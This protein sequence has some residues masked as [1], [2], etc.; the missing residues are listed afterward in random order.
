MLQDLERLRTERSAW[1]EELLKQQEG[2]IADQKIT[3]KRVFNTLST[4]E[5]KRT[6]VAL[7]E[8][9]S[10]TEKPTAV[11]LD[12]PL[13]NLDYGNIALQIKTIRRIQEESS[14]AFIIVSHDNKRELLEGLNNCEIINLEPQSNS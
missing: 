8:I 4:G 12:E 11:I 14:V 3:A 13:S 9:A 2:N 7:A 10:Q 1:I 5:Q 6:L